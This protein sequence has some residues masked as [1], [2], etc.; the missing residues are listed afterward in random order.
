MNY[1]ILGVN[2]ILVHNY[3]DIGT[4]SFEHLLR[5][6]VPP[7]W[8]NL[9][10]IDR[11]IGRWTLWSD[12]LGLVWAGDIQL[13]NLFLLWNDQKLHPRRTDPS[14]YLRHLWVELVYLIP[15]MLHTLCLVHL[16]DRPRVLGVQTAGIRLGL[17]RTH[18]RQER[19]ARGAE[20]RPQRGQETRKEIE[21]GRET[22]SQ[23]Y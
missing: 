3:F 17:H 2:V 1:L 19:G 14:H 7:S 9:Q 12:Q 20:D 22:Q 8:S 15:A 10:R 6:Q 13:D 21:E 11:G 18:K 5:L 23:V 4:L 16:P